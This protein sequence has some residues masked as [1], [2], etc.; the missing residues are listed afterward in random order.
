M[1]TTPGTALIIHTI[2]ASASARHDLRPVP[3][4]R[5]WEKAWFALTPPIAAAPL[6][7]T[8]INGHAGWTGPLFLAAPLS[9][10]AIV[11]HHVLA[12]RAPSTGD[13]VTFGRPGTAVTPTASHT[14]QRQN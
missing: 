7:C 6:I 4:F 5:L 2:P 14:T 10:L 3:M 1:S 13:T 12:E 8:L 9:A 11:A